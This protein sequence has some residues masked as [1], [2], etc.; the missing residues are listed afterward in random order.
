MIKDNIEYCRNEKGVIMILG[1]ILNKIENAEIVLPAIQRSFVWED[2]QIYNLL[3]SILRG[4]PIGIILS[5]E[6]YD[7]IRYRNFDWE[8]RSESLYTYYDNNE[9][10]KIQL[11]LDGQQRLQSLFIA[12]KGAYE[13]MELYLDL[14][15]GRDKRDLSGERFN[16][17]FLTKE[18]SITLN[19]PEKI[20]K[21][22]F[23]KL[24]DIINMGLD[25]RMSL[26][27]EW[28]VKLKLDE[29]QKSKIEYNLQSIQFR[30][31]QDSNI[32]Q[33]SVIDENL[34]FDNKDRKK[35][36]DILE[37]FVRIN[38]SG[39]PLSRSDL[40]ISMLRLNWRESSESLPEFVVLI[41]KANGFDFDTDFV[42]RCLYAVSDLG[43]KFD[44]DLLR[45]VQNV[46]KIKQNFPQCCNAIK[47]SID[48]VQ[49]YCSINH[50]Y[51]IGNN[52][53]LIPLVYYLFHSPDQVVQNS[54]ISL[55]KKAMLLLA[56]TNPF[57]R[58][59]DSRLWKFI[60]EHIIPL[61][62]R[63]RRPF[64][65]HDL[66]WWVS[67]WEGYEDL[68]IYML[69]GNYE[70]ACAL[71]QGI[72]NL[73]VLN[74]KNAPEMDHIFPKAVLREKGFKDDDIHS[75]ANFWIL[76]QNKNRNKSKTHPK[77]YFADYNNSELK[78]LFIDKDL[79]DYRYFKKFLEYRSKKMLKHIREIFAY[80]RSDFQFKED[81][82]ED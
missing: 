46:N 80:E 9:K 18:K 5:W 6:T 30:L 33:T 81:E 63:D 41:N 16:F 57:S 69:S 12:L 48:F 67:Y 68:D 58:Y 28:S 17:R 40:I 77:E 70:L 38:K 29:K 20:G 71:V 49:K 50:A 73:S 1:Q 32:L 54:Q 22:L 8:Y 25:Q 78:R 34:P 65:F 53:N 82:F 51:T 4:Y 23:V 55:V 76:E 24:K 27:K 11:V 7:A 64:P 14:L 21:K 43:T 19:S 62:D 56:F 31:F 15:S 26:V 35:E 2:K 37:I 60:S 44:I 39:T 47:S 10:K 74:E 3:D 36:S 61:N 72:T 13:G 79:F 52:V 66:A 45:N 59:A 42:V 75:V